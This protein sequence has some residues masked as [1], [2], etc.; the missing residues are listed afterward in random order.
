MFLKI[1]VHIGIHQDMHVI[2]H[3]VGDPK[4]QTPTIELSYLI[5]MYTLELG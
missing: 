5:Q 1:S 4:R 3:I 2:E